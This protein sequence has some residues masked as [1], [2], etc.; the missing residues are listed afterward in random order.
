[1]PADTMFRACVDSCGSVTATLQIYFIT[2]SCTVLSYQC[3]CC[4]QWTEPDDFDGVYEEWMPQ[5]PRQTEVAEPAPAQQQDSTNEGAEVVGMEHGRLGWVKV[6]DQ[7]GYVF[8]FHEAT[9][10]TQWEQPA[11]F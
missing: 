10:V 1:M 3:E 9:G 4:L 5:P 7:D 6:L 2:L 8:Y 11:E